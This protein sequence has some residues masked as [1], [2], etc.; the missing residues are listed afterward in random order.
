MSE[1]PSNIAQVKRAWHRVP[2][3]EKRE[4]LTNAKAKGLEACILLTLFG[5]SGAFGLGMASILLGTAVLLPLLYQVI[6]VR[7]WRE[8]RPRLIAKYMVAEHTASQYAAS[9]QSKDPAPK[10]L[11]RGNL[12]PPMKLIA[13]KYPEIDPEDLQAHPIPVWVSLFPDHLIMIS[14]SDTGAKLEFAHSTLEHFRL[15]TDHSEEADEPRDTME[16]E[17]DSPEGESTRWILK[18]PHTSAMLACE[19]KIRL[20]GERAHAEREQMQLGA[21]Q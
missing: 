4:L 11:F 20:F 21:G 15:I 6:S 18:T 1:T 7:A 14:E 12:I 17:T 3:E 13:Q 5:A 8:G 2:E 19:K 10:A 9:M 16:I